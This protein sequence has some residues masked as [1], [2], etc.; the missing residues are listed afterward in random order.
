MAG[1]D[2]I[3][4]CVDEIRVRIRLDV[5]AEPFLRDGL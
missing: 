1:E 4:V 2:G 5:L 3:G